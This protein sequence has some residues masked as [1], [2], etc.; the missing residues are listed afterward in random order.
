MSTATP[1]SHLAFVERILK[2]AIDSRASEARLAAGSVPVVQVDGQFRPLGKSPVSADDVAG[3]AAALMPAGGDPAA[4]SF[5]TAT[6]SGDGMLV[7]RDGMKLLVLRGIAAEALKSIHG[8][9]T[10][11]K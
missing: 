3:I 9:Q 5:T 10:K 7:E 8:K 6:A 2:V 1:P 4:F 11:T